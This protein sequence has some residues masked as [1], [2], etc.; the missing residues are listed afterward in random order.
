MTAIL[1]LLI[2]YSTLAPKDHPGTFHAVAMGNEI[3]RTDTRTGAMERC[4]VGAVV[5]C[6]PV[7]VSAK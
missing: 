5:I 1:I 7:L 3:I 4:S 6:A 2:E